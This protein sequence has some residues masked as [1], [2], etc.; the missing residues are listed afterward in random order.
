MKRSHF[1]VKQNAENVKA[2][3]KRFWG[4][5]RA[6]SKT[7]IRAA[8]SA[9]L[10]LQ[11]AAGAGGAAVV[12]I[13]I[14]LCLG[15]GILA[16]PFG[17]LAHFETDK[18]ETPLVHGAVPL[19]TA[20]EQINR[21]YTSKIEDM[22][23]GKTDSLY[24][25]VDGN[26]EGGYEPQNWADVLAVFAVKVALD[27]EN[28]MDV[29]ELDKTRV[30]LLRR[31]F[32]DMNEI[33]MRT[34]SEV[35]TEQVTDPNTGQTTTVERT[36]SVLCIEGHSD[37]YTDM[38]E[39]YHLNKDQQ[40]VLEQ[41]TGSEFWPY[42][43]NIVSRSLGETAEDWSGT[44]VN[45]VGGMKIPVLYQYNYKQR[46]CTINGQA[47]S[48]STSGCGA[49]SASMVIAYLTGNTRQTPYTLFKW[50]YDTGRY[51]GDGLDHGTI[52]KMCSNYGVTCTWVGNTERNVLNALQ[53][54]YPVIAHMGPGIFTKGGHYIVLRGVTADG[55][56]LVN[57][58]NSAQRTKMA[59]PL[60]TII[61]QLR[62]S[63]CIGVCRKN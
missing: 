7:A 22:T 1:L 13:V 54:G 11:A 14:I 34:E 47:K 27:P 16:S 59:F 17:I 20:I 38:V 29:I 43:R 41:L 42:W 37:A 57:D 58:P 21:E 18:G 4:A 62:R 51:S 33:Q 9:A 53:N 55:K 3:A 52:S 2:G 35:Y 46:V 6:S 8:R 31:I 60:S 40:A 5:L 23:K 45:P 50:A 28:A 26:D 63:N 25:A 24:I 49:T 44:V 39:K 15:A 19:T 10:A 61:K 12:A 32:W 48:V 30:E 56:I 36:R